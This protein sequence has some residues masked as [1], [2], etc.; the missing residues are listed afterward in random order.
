M[1]MAGR[2][3]SLVGKCIHHVNHIPSFHTQQVIDGFPFSRFQYLKKL[4]VQSFINYDNA[5]SY[6]FSLFMFSL[7][8]SFKYLLTFTQLMISNTLHSKHYFYDC[9]GRWLL[10]TIDKLYFHIT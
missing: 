5:D 10:Q 7:Q 9:K 2:S 1:V 6:H 8:R 4:Q 3:N